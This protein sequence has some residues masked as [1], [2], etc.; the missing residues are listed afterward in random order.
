MSEMNWEDILMENQQE[1]KECI[2]KFEPE[3]VEIFYRHYGEN[4]ERMPEEMLVQY[5]LTLD[6]LNAILGFEKIH[7]QKIILMRLGIMTGIPMELQE[8]AK[9]FGGSHS[10]YERIQQIEKKFIRKWK[11]P[12]RSRK[13]RDF[14][15]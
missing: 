12:S 4:L 1:I 6:M 14:L 5:K 3:I 15:D 11:H 10:T 7:H 13:L 8:I 9:F 2:R